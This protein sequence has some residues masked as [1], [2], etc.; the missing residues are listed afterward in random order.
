[1]P[2]VTAVA[3]RPGV[4]GNQRETEDTVVERDDRAVGPIEAQGR[5]AERT[6]IDSKRDIGAIP[7]AFDRFFAAI[8]GPVTDKFG[9]HAVD[10]NGGSVGFVLVCGVGIATRIELYRRV[11]ARPV[12]ETVDAVV[13]PVDAE[14]DPA[15]RAV[16]TANEV[17]A[18]KDSSSKATMYRT[19]SAAIG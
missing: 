6:V 19:R 17:R 13:D 10:P 7:I 1:M 9:V 2:A 16:R 15:A 3:A 8:P 18:S 5:R 14:V 11:L 4:V 12:G